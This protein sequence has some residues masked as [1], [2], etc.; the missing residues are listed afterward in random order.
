M[1]TPEPTTNPLREPVLP[2]VVLAFAVL[3]YI[4]GGVHEPWSD[5]A[6]AW[7]IARDASLYDLLFVLPHG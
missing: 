7:L 2:A 5:E 4:I 1:E 6:Q 3:A